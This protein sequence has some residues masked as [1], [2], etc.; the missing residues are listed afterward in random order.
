MKA[1]MLSLTIVL[2]LLTGSLCLGLEIKG[3]VMDTPVTVGNFNLMD[4]DGHPFDQSQ[5][6]QG[7]NLI[8]FGFTNCGHICPVHMLQISKFY[9]ELQALPAKDKNL[10]RV[11]FVSVDP[12]RDTVAKVKDYVN[13]FHPDFVGLTGDET[14]IQQLEASL[15]ASH[16]ANLARNGNYQ[17][18]HSSLLYLV[19]GQQQ[20]VASFYPPFYIDK[21]VQDYLA[22]LNTQPAPASQP[23][24]A[25]QS[26]N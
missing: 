23:L 6:D 10:P 9:R 19:N 16:K 21:L 4:Q 26:A 17:V 22:V 13:G 12:A 11:I 1:L 8:Y 24:A 2:G 3:D 5:L 25:L 18:D 7:W 14:Q 15:S 20:L